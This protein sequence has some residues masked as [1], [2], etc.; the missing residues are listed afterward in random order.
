MLQI[1]PEYENSYAKDFARLFMTEGSE[2]KKFLFGTNNLAIE[3][4]K[5]LPVDGYINTYSDKKE[6]MGK[7][8]L[9]KIEAIPENAL[10]LSCVYLGSIIIIMRKLSKFRFRSCDCY[11]FIKAAKL[12]IELFHFTG[13][14]EDIETHREKYNT[15]FDRLEDE[16][17]KNVFQNLVNFK[18]SG[19]TKYLEGFNPPTDEQYFD[20]CLELPDN[21]V[22]AD[23]GGYDGLTTKKFI[24]HYPSYKEVFFFEPEAKNI[25]TAKENLSDYKNIHFIQKGL[26]DKNTTLHFSVNESASMICEDGESSIEVAKLDDVVN[27]EINFLKM[28]IEG[29]EGGA[30]EGAKNTIK[31]WHPNMAICVYHKPD[32]FWKIPEQVLSIRDDY[33]LFMRHYTQGSDETVMFFIPKH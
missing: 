28:D 8:L 21:P 22:F 23:I 26:S 32:D 27:S 2:Y 11:S 7:P 24:E 10:V 13:W 5:I 4:S 33:K 25:K 3:L 1:Y 17:S 9:N 19:D 14:K 16:E 12:P 31:K 15:V 29:A 20:D 30:I 18:F 6:F